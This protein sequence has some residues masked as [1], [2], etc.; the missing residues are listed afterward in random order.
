MPTTEELEAQVKDLK[1]QITTLIA[2]NDKT[3]ISTPKFLDFPGEAGTKALA[4][5]R[6]AE[7]TIK[8]GG[9]KNETAQI[10]AARVSMSKNVPAT[11]WLDNLKDTEKDTWENFRKAFCLRWQIELEIYAKCELFLQC[12]QKQGVS[13]LQF[14]DECLDVVQHYFKGLPPEAAPTT[15]SGST[16]LKHYN[17]GYFN[18]VAHIRFIM[19]V[20]GLLPQIRSELKKIDIKTKP[21]VT[22]STGNEVVTGSEKHFDAVVEAACRIELSLTSNRY[23]QTAAVDS[24]AKVQPLAA[25]NYQ[26]R[27]RGSARYQG[28]LRGRY[29][30]NFGNFANRGRGST[31]PQPTSQSPTFQCWRCSGN[32]HYARQCPN[33]PFQRAQP[34]R[35]RGAPLQN[36]PLT[37]ISGTQNG[38]QTEPHEFTG[39]R[40]DEIPALPSHTNDYGDTVSFQTHESN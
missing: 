1:A 26:G 38:G 35:G 9:F 4:W 8:I 21:A 20:N 12:K 16:T 25:F 36:R 18:C 31:G 19:F 5:L 34:P 22:D 40:F 24:A 10:G 23:P 7:A 2:K 32:N 37:A 33:Q 15:G 3:I 27:G 39:E 11:L 13:V 29:R 14:K 30:P 6:Q 28:G 17:E